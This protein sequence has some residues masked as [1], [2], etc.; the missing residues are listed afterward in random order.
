MEVLKTKNDLD[1]FSDAKIRELIARV[2]KQS[3]KSRIQIAEQLSAL[4]GLPVTV[5][6][7]N[8]WCTKK[9]LR[10]PL[11]LAAAFCEVTGTND[12]LLA[13]MGDQLRRRVILG[14]RAVE[15]RSLLAAMSDEAAILAQEA[16]AKRKRYRRAK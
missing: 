1:R 8:D 5:N 7:L 13:A 6:M 12:L 16:P 3:R 14:H 10:F 15:L 11:S 9:R 2:L 4:T